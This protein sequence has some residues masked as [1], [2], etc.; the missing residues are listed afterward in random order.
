M[1]SVDLE[2]V[3]QYRGDVLVLGTEIVGVAEQLLESG[4]QYRKAVTGWFVCADG[5]WGLLS[6]RHQPGT[7]KG[8]QFR[9][10]TPAP[11]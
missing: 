2:I 11:R 7:V 8:V 6:D 5:R 4:S 10:V 1:S 9:G 3:E